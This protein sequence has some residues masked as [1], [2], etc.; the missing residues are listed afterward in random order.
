MSFWRNLMPYNDRQPMQ[1][2]IAD[3][4]T[5]RFQPNVV[6][7]YL[8]D[9]GSITLDQIIAAFDGYGADLEQFAQLIDSSF[10]YYVDLPYVSDDALN[11]MACKI[12]HRNVHLD[13]VEPTWQP[14]VRDEN[15][16]IC[17]RKNSVVEYLVI[18]N[19]LTI[20][21]LIKSRT[22]FP[23]ADFEQLFMLCGYSVDA[24]TSEIVVRQSTVAILHKKAKLFM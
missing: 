9:N 11:E 12:N 23:I 4:D 10:D 8:L 15:G 2:I 14:L 22:I 18:N 21:E 7:T 16:G 24:F 17:F 6:I 3:N 19:T 13:R 20:A 5:Y 1:V